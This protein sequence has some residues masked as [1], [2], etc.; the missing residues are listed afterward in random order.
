MPDVRH[1]GGL[2][3]VHVLD[4]NAIG[5]KVCRACYWREWY[6]G[7][8]D[9]HYTNGMGLVE[10][11]QRLVAAGL[12]E[13]PSDRGEREANALARR[14][15]YELVELLQDARPGEHL[16]VVRCMNCGRQSVLRVRDVEYGCTCMKSKKWGSML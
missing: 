5:E 2:P 16:L 1:K 4:K 3:L 13:A 9:I 12:E 8:E 11:K 14:S 6:R 7:E 10:A 15:G